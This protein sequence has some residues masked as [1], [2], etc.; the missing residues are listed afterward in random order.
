MQIQVIVERVKDNG[1]RVRAK[2]PFT[3][4]AKGA[5]REEALA[6]LRAKIQ[7]RLKHGTEVVG[8]EIGP[9]SDPWMEFAGM[10]KGDP[11]NSPP[12][13]PKP[14]SRV[15]RGRRLAVSIATCRSV[16]CREAPRPIVLDGCW[17]WALRVS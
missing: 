11:K 14:G 9:E 2:D 3:V 10:L 5:T 16:S 17:T 12:V 13:P 1:Y 6:K 15:R 4:S 7:S 8:L